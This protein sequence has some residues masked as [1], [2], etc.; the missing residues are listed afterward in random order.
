M[1]LSRDLV[2]NG[3]PDAL[4][5][6]VSAFDYSQA[7]LEIAE[8]ALNYNR[9]LLDV[10]RGYGVVSEQVQ[11]SAILDRSAELNPT[12]HWERTA[13]RAI[14][15]DIR[16]SIGAICSGIFQGST[17]PNAIDEF[18]TKNRDATLA[19]SEWLQEFS[20]RAM[21]LGALVVVNGHL[22]SLTVA[23]DPRG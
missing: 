1:I 9:P 12:D 11:V 17:E 8:L 5:S 14:I 2:A 21:T 19:I 22:Q 10:A 6:R 13:R 7:L 3:F 16:E 4:I 15:S 18:L 23:S 20:K